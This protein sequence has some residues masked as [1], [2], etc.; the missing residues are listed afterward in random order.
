MR[1]HLIDWV[2]ARARLWGIAKRRLDLKL[3]NWPESVWARIRDGVP[4]ESFREQHFAEVFE[5]DALI[6]RRSLIV[7]TAKQY[8]HVYA[9]YVINVQIKVKIER[10][11][12]SRENYYDTLCNAH[13]K[14]ARD[15]GSFTQS[16]SSKKSSILV[17]PFC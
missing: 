16:S 7:L 9:H 6:F 3:E 15:M 5:G 14:L 10:M 2:D 1:A 13:R 17:K 12:H 4:P 11:G 8:C